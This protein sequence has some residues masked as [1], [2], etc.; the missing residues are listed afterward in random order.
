MQIT[1][2]KDDMFDQL[3]SPIFIESNDQIS[4]NKNE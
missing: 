1:D 3:F 4:R 2:S